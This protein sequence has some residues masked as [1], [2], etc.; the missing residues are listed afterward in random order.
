MGFVFREHLCVEVVVFD[1]FLVFAE[2]GSEGSGVGEGG[3]G[4]WVFRGGGA[5]GDASFAIFGELVDE[6]FVVSGGFGEDG[7]AVVVES[8]GVDGTRS[9]CFGVFVVFAR[10]E[11]GDASFDGAPDFRSLFPCDGGVPTRFCGIVAAFVCFGILLVAA[12]GVFPLFVVFF[13]F[14][15]FVVE[16]AFVGAE[17]FF[18]F[19]HV[20]GVIGHESAVGFERGDGLVH[21]LVLFGESVCLEQVVCGVD[22]DFGPRSIAR[23]FEE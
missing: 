19:R 9:E 13:F 16:S 21:L 8:D 7:Q 5:D 15:E 2:S 22:G 23:D 11:E 12:G 4:A 3:F 10:G 14:A 20:S 1:G 6:D 18:E 17:D